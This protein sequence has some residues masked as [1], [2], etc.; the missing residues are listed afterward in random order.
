MDYID[1]LRLEVNN[2]T[3]WV[4]VL[5]PTHDIR[6][7]RRGLE[8]GM[9]SATVLD[10]VVDPT[11]ATSIRPGRSVRLQALISGVWTTIYAG[12]LSKASVT[13]VGG[14]RVSLEAVDD[15]A[16][17]A[18]MSEPEG[19][20]TVD[21]LRYL[22][23][24]TGLQF[25]VNGNTAGLGS[26]TVVT[27]NENARLLDQVVMTRDSNL[28]YA[29]VDRENVI[30]VYNSL[31]TTSKATFTDVAG[32]FSYSDI[33][34]SFDSQNLI[35]DVTVTLQYAGLTGNT[36]TMTY[37]PFQDA[38]SVSTWGPYSANFT[39][40]GMAESAIST[41][42]ASIL[43]ANSTPTI[44]VNRLTTPIRQQ[45][46]VNTLSKLDLY[47]YVTV[48]HDGTTYTD[49]RITEI[50]HQITPDL[51]QITLSFEKHGA[52]AAPLPVSPPPPI[53]SSDFPDPSA[54]DG[55]APADAPEIVVEGG[56]GTLF[57]KWDEIANSD[58]VTYDVYIDDVTPVTP[59]SLTYVGSTMGTFF[60]VNKMP[61]G[62]PLVYGTTY[63]VTVIPRD[64]DGTGPASN[65]ASGGTILIQ[66]VDLVD[67]AVTA[68]KIGASAVDATKLADN[69]VSAAKIVDNA[70]GTAKLVDGSVSQFK[71]AA[72]SVT[73]DKVVAGA[74]GTDALA[75]NSVVAGKIA[76]A[77]ITA[78]QIAAN[79][80]TSDKIAANTITASNIAANAITADKLNANSVTAGKIA[81]GAIDGMTI[82]GGLLQTSSLSN[83][84]V[85]L[86]S[87]GIAAWNSS[88]SLRL[89]IDSNTGSFLSYDSTIYGGLFMTSSG[90]QRLE[91]GNTGL[92]DPTDEVRMFNNG[93]VTSMRHLTG[94]SGWI[95]FNL[96]SGAI[97]LHPTSDGWTAIGRGT[98]G[99]RLKFISSGL[100]CRNGSDSGYIPIQASAFTVSSSPA[101]KENVAAAGV[102]P[103]T[104]L[105]N[106]SLKKWNWKEDFLGIPEVT[107]RAAETFADDEPG[108]PDETLAQKQTRGQAIKDALLADLNAKHAK[109]EYGLMVDELPAWLQEGDGYNLSAVIGFLWEALKEANTRIAALEAGP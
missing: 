80:I 50:E 105:P 69:S 96:S 7:T 47:D 46:E 21:E 11:V 54:T 43:A 48:T 22:F 59:G 8:V 60:L 91:M 31:T 73:A 40:Q 13:Y 104:I 41:Y 15:V 12:R 65:T 68:A 36:E 89:F 102:T 98:G 6:I 70:V 38:T 56:I 28:A 100:Q 77:T 33:D 35:N 107:A 76:T 26:A 39:V 4:N 92:G 87:S 93:T 9:L 17:M 29:W 5:G 27:M 79:T 61:N 53:P 88:G 45:T 2:G 97:A 71:L 30:N 106:A 34:I 63:Y 64:E 20:A 16:R 82:T 23:N 25:R 81:A 75:A 94:S 62:D 44:R 66:T 103:S 109:D 37:G 101:Y 90:S 83:R 84:G 14:T 19:V 72:G 99:P 78:L 74:I 57:V 52:V 51:W 1:V 32:S 67:G 18:N 42:A 55:L 49:T 108:P 85:K 24:G 86:Y 95:Y 3:S 58:I 10:S